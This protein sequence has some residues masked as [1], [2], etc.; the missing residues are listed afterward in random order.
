MMVPLEFGDVP[1]ANGAMKN[2]SPDVGPPLV[3]LAPN[4]GLKRDRI[5]YHTTRQ[6]NLHVVVEGALRRLA[7]PSL[8]E[9]GADF[10]GG[11]EG[12]DD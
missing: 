3:G 11:W 4:V 2:P 7:E 9:L 6:A 1:Q 8:L 5:A 12:E 10:H